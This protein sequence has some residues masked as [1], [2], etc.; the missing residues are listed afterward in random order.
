ME[1]PQLQ[2]L[3]DWGLCQSC[4]MVS[5]GWNPAHTTAGPCPLCGE[6]DFGVEWPPEPA[7]LLLNQAFAPLGG[8]VEEVLD[9]GAVGQDETAGTFYYD[10]ELE[11]RKDLRVL[12]EQEQAAVKAFLVTTALDVVMEWVFKAAAE[13]FDPDSPE[14]AQL[15]E[16]RHE[17]TLTTEQRLDLLRKAGAPDLRDLAKDEDEPR[18]PGW[19]KEFRNRQDNFLHRHSM[20]AFDGVTTEDLLDVARMGVKVLAAFNNALW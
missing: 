12:E 5:E 13:S 8:Q 17:A 1:R 10:A 3:F 15:S 18:F 19:W 4:M 2:A 16:P 20:C 9:V 14:F 6:N 11:E 7:R